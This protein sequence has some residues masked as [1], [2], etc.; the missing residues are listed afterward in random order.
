MKKLVPILFVSAFALALAGCSEPEPVD[1]TVTGELTDSDPRVEQ[2]DSPYDEYR[3][4]VAE[5]WTITGDAEL[6]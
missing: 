3:F 2:D 4:D 6:L 1:E 5:G